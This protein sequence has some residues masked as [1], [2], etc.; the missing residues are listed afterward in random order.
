MSDFQANA[1]L[2]QKVGAASKLSRLGKPQVILLTFPGR[3]EPEW[4]D[5]HENLRLYHAGLISGFTV[6]TPP[7]RDEA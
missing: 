6:G 7:S 1:E 2:L 5:I 4:D 3:Y